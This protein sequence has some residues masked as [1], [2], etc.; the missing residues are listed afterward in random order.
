M[1]DTL[2][3]FGKGEQRNCKPKKIEIHKDQNFK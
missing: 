3:P 1:I 2:E